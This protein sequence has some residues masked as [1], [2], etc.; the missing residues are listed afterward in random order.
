MA[1]LARS[2]T[3]Y[4]R[5]GGTLHLAAPSYVE[6]PAD[7]E[8]FNHLLAGRFCYVLTS[9]Q[10]GK[11]SLMLRT[12]ER[13][14]Q[15]GL[16]TAIVDLSSLGTDQVTR[17]QWYLGLI[18]R[19]GLELKLPV[20]PEAWWHA[21]SALTPVQRF[22]DFLH[23]EVL[24][25][26]PVVIFIDEIDSTLKLPF[27]D[28]FF[29]AIRYVYNQRASHPEYD[30]LTFAL[31]GVASPTDLI[32]DRSRT[33][34]NIGQAIDLQEL[35]RADAEPLRQGLAQYFPGRD[36]ALLDR[37]FSWTHG[38]PY[39]T[40]KLCYEASQN[41]QG[42]PEAIDQ[43]VD[44]LFLQ[45]TPGK[46]DNLQF[47]RSNVAA[48]PAR[49]KMMQLYLRVYEGQVVAEDEL[50]PEQRWLKLIGLVR[51][52]SRRLVVR[53]EIYR[54]VFDSDWAKQNMPREV[55]QYIFWG[56][57]IVIGLVVV[58]LWGLNWWQTQQKL[59]VQRQTYI[60]RFNRSSDADLRLNA[61]AGLCEPQLE[62]QPEAHRLFFALDPVA[63]Q[64]IFDKVW[65]DEA[66]SQLV[67]VTRCLLPT[68]PN[69]VR[70]E[71]QR[72]DLIESMH[73]AL[74][75]LDQDENTDFHSIVSKADCPHPPQ[76]EDDYE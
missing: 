41:G 8:L 73:R 32:R 38:H 45:E 3:D 5:V 68:L 6:R 44:D 66:G 16:N 20:E 75:R 2:T 76:S 28:D 23:D 43:L 74:C 1:T 59:N 13:L 25:D 34:F 67:T 55:T 37:I 12:A 52:K 36:E 64:E 42:T 7:A 26:S 39:L 15:A 72:A 11:S 31:L 33:P 21:R 22:T 56:S 61:L 69:S 62:A 57:I 9:R 51:A 71:D 47:I 40:Q 70:D 46:D 60:E 35:S 48:N 10:M 19:I 17:E 58:G 18:K 14:R 29:A 50:S 27:T 65:A 30:R 4:F 54:R 53:N 24:G 49:R 63:Q